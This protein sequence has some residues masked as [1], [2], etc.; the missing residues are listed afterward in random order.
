MLQQLVHPDV[1]YL[2]NIVSGP[3]GNTVTIRMERHSLHKP[4]RDGQL[5][6]TVR[7]GVQTDRQIVVPSLLMEGVN[8]LFVHLVPHSYCLVIAC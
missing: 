7:T 5:G 6:K 1:P 2:D 8:T 4:A 3:G